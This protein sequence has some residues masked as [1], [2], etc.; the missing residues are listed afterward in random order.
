MRTDWLTRLQMALDPACWRFAWQVHRLYR[1]DRCYNPIRLMLASWRLGRQERILRVRG[2]YLV[3][4]FLPPVPSRAFLQH[5]AATPQPDQRFTQQ[6]KAQRS[7]PISMF[8]EVTGRCDCSCVH[9]SARDRRSQGEL[10]LQAWTHIIAKLQ[11]MGVSIFGLTGGEPLLRDDLERI[12]QAIDDRSV[13]YVF[14]NGRH[15]TGERARSLAD[16]GLFGLGVSLDSPTAEEHDA[17][18]GAPGSHACALQAMEHAARAGLHVMAQCVVMPGDLDETRLEAICRLARDHGAREVRLLEP[19]PSGALRAAHAE[20]SFLTPEDRQRLIAFQHQANRQTDM[21][22][23]TSFAWTESPQ[24]YGCGAGTQHSYI[25]CNGDLYPC[26]FVPM[27][28]GNVL[29]EDI[30]QLWSAMNRMIGLPKP[31]CFAFTVHQHL[32][33]APGPLPLTGEQAASL[34]A[35]CRAT[36]LPGFY[37]TLRRGTPLE[38][39]THAR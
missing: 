23:V 21:P 35:A 13:S 30:S 3:S 7:A 32:Q 37:R 19:I 25:A 4:S 12:I 11:Q 20:S 2:G 9:C 39:M 5:L 34:C 8:L 29:Q 6:L 26:D 14:T 22:R 31:A 24:Q 28:F 15:V 10:S 36:E 27:A 38:S 33:N 16:S 18:R 17:R 1:N